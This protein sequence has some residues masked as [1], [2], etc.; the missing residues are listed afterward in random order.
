MRVPVFWRNAL[1][2]VVVEPSAASTTADEYFYITIEYEFDPGVKIDARE[3]LN[4]LD[5]PEN[6][7]ERKGIF[8]A[9]EALERNPHWHHQRT[10]SYTLGISR[11]RLEQVGGVAYLNDVDLVVGFEKHRDDALHPYSQSG[12]RE[13]LSQGLEKDSGLTQR[14]LLVDNSGIY[15]SRWVNTGYDV[16]ELRPTADPRMRDGVYVSIYTPLHREP[17][18]HF[19]ELADAE[20]ALGLYR[21]R[22]EAEAFGK[23]ETRF[24]AELKQIEH[25][26][27][28][29]KADLARLKQENER[30]RH[31]MDLEKQR[32][33]DYFKAEEQRRKREQD[34][35]DAAQK[36][37]QQEMERQREQMRMERERLE[38]ERQTFSDRKKFEY[39]NFSRERKDRSDAF[40][41]A[42]E[43]G[44][45][46][47]GI[48]S[49]GLSVYALVKKNQK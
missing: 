21:N 7:S 47:L 35:L 48:L 2:M 40:K 12:Q 43:V 26:L 39:D 37:H 28:L 22:A 19:Y 16:F 46:V 33:D 44:K 30:E 15:G 14:Y 9:L 31:D 3:L 23:P 27:V 24:A 42:L 25:D 13:R 8:S 34:E 4:E 18:T 41:G 29:Q 36:R 10:F 49:V 5:L 45:A 6:H 38:F 1:G 20:K 32:Q 11:E 17:K